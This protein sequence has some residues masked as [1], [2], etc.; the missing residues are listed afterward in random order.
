MSLNIQSV[1]NKIDEFSILLNDFHDPEL[2]VLCEHWLKD[3][4]PLFIPNYVIVDNYC[5]LNTSCGG[6]LIMIREDLLGYYS[7]VCFDM[8]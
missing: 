6:T 5:R 7:F 2:I 8:D 3:L 1:R 4:E